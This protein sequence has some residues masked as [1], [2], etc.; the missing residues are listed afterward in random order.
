ML[1]GFDRSA[2]QLVLPGRPGLVNYIVSVA[3]LRIR[4][5]IVS[6]PPLIPLL[7]AMATIEVTL[8]FSNGGGDRLNSGHPSC[9][10]NQKTSAQEEPRAPD[11]CFS[12]VVSGTYCTPYSARALMLPSAGDLS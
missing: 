4:E 8:C 6:S 5:F 12:R 10:H 9:D 2:P 3:K 11:S 7:V 1:G